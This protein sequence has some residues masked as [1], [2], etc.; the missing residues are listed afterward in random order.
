MFNSTSQYSC[1][2]NFAPNK[3]LK[4]GKTNDLAPAVLLKKKKRDREKKRP[5][6][7]LISFHQPKQEPVISLTISE[8]RTLIGEKA[9][10]RLTQ[11]IPQL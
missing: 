10:N 6:K 8:I 3:I 1:Q 7:L 2:V 11:C 9:F 5:Q 4:L